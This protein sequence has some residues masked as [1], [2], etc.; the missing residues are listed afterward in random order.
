MIHCATLE[1][2]KELEKMQFL[3]VL[4]FAFTFFSRLIMKCAITAQSAQA[5]QIYILEII[6]LWDVNS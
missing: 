2:L 4:N 5:A 3:F 6:K 1:I